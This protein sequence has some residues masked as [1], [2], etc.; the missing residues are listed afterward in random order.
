MTKLTLA[1]LIEAHNLMVSDLS[2]AS[3][4]NTLQVWAMVLE[5]RVRRESATAVIE[6]LN[7]LCKTQYT[8]DDLSVALVEEDQR[9]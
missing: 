3:G 4:V 5:H 7:L 6:A 2:N 9:S 1:N 8:L